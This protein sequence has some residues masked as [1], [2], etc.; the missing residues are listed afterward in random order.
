[1][2][3]T[4]DA[5]GRTTRLEYSGGSCVSCGGGKELTG[6]ID[7]NGNP[8]RW[9][10]DERGRKAKEI[11]TNGAE[12][13]YSYTATGQLKTTTDPKG[14][15]KSY[16]YNRDGT[17]AGIQYAVATGTSPTPNVSFT[18]DEAY[19][20]VLTVT[21]GTGTTRY[22]YHTVGSPPTLG[23]GKLRSVDGPLADDTIEYGYDELG[24]VSTRQIG[25]GGNTQTQAFDALGRLTTLGNALGSFTYTY[26]GVTGRPAS[27][28][29]PNGQQ[30]TWAYYDNLGDHR[31]RE[32][33]NKRPGGA[34]LS[35][36]E[37]TYDQ[38]G[39][40]LTWLQQ[41]DS[42]PAKAYVL[43]YD[44]TDQLTSAVLQT[45]DPVPAIL[46]RYYYSYD[47]AGNRTAE[48]IDD[49][50]TGASHNHMNQLVSQQA[51]GALAFKG[52]VSEPA[53]VAVGGHPAT[54]TADN[55]FE[56]QAVVPSGT[57]QVAVTATDPSGNV[58][59]STYQV[60]QGATSKSFTYDLNGNTTSDGTRTFEWDAENR[61]VA[62]K[63]GATTIAS[64]TYNHRGI[65][66][67]KTTAAGTISYVLEAGSVVEERFGGGVRKHHQGPGL[68]TVLAMQDDT[69]VVSY[70]LR[71]HL[72]SI[73]EQ[74]DAT[75][76][77]VTLRRDYDPWGNMSAGASTNG[78]AY[79]GREWDAETEL[80]Y[81]R[82]RYYGS[83]AGRFT[84]ED[85]IALAGG[86]NLYAYIGGRV[87]VGTDPLG[88]VIHISLTTAPSQYNVAT[89]CSGDAGGTCYKRTGGK[90]GPCRKKDSCYGFNVTVD[91]RIRK[92][93]TVT[94]AQATAPGSSADSPGLSLEEHEDLHVQDFKVGLADSVINSMIKTE[95][96]GSPQECMKARKE[97][98]GRIDAFI[99]GVAL[100]SHLIR[101]RW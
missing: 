67:S 25:S 72:G 5:A 99:D 68:D 6:L 47:P 9:E 45:T 48:Q 37:Y 98:I 78:W 4:R 101:D 76:T 54:V 65:R 89:T 100:G 12:Y 86:P 90:L 56:G 19:S 18:Y 14:N 83:G 20:R 66:T 16:V 55:R 46:K 84:S 3:G 61:L 70:L 93:F 13:L 85:P 87:T 22:S 60:S 74:V 79:T 11:R 80:Y 36:F 7:A 94:Q 21:D 64:F 44:K 73:R 1:M 69:G 39:N 77:T 58:R 71:D 49:A 50:V 62:V 34:T 35:R 24:R 23:A 75:G 82:A 52:T 33:H 63:E 26:E 28:T 43:G 95:G 40:I 32:I 59:T 96:F 88:Y 38:A 57:G 27:L 91:V 29:Y 53:N 41:A 15:V 42:D 92:E 81:Y 51:G 2:A 17:L 30:T 10:Y 8:T 31:L 97:I